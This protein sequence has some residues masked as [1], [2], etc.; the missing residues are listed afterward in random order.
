MHLTHLFQIILIILVIGCI[1]AAIANDSDPLEI[2]DLKNRPAEEII[3]IIQPLLKPGDAIT[4]T[5]FQ[6]FIRTDLQ[7]LDDIKRLLSQLDKSPKNLIISI[8]NATDINRDFSEFDVS[9]NYEVGDD[10]RVIVG[11][12]PPIKGGTQVRIDAGNQ[13]RQNNATHTVRVLEGASAFIAAG[14]VRPHRN[15]TVIHRRDGVT[16]YEDVGYQDVTS[17]FYVTPRLTGNGNVTLEVQPHYR[18]TANGHSGAIN[19]QEASMTLSTKLGQWS[20]IGGIET[21][22]S[23][24]GTGVINKS[25]S[26]SSQQTGLY[27]KVDV[28]N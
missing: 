16:V 19:V 23:S 26:S 14:E 27:I 4:G 18:S 5:G 13:N 22:S 21:Q 3:P 11:N 12:D 17:G 8:R 25:K 24:S 15:R 20:K 2:I 10:G 6:L 1:S 28:E 7:R 9:G